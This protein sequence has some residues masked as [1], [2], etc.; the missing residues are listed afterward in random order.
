MRASYAKSAETGDSGASAD[1]RAIIG[2][3]GPIFRRAR[4]TSRQATREL[5][6]HRAR[7]IVAAVKAAGAAP[8]EG[9][10]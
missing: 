3:N 8:H 10:V 4:L 5:T 6:S 7:Q 1:Y 9:G 2:S